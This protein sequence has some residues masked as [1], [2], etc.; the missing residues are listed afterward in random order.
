MTVSYELVD[1][2]TIGVSEG[3]PG[4]VVGV[5]GGL[6]GGGA[7]VT[8]PFDCRFANAYTFEASALSCRSKTSIA[9]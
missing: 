1:E 4:G 7:V 6:T 9:C 5:F 2:V 8:V 3:F